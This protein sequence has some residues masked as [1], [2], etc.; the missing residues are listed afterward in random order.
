MNKCVQ[1]INGLAATASTND[2]L[3]QIKNIEKSSDADSVTMFFTLF[4][5]AYDKHRTFGVKQIPES[6]SV[7]KND[8]W[9]A[10]ISLVD[11]LEQRSLTGHAARDAIQ[12]LTDTTDADIWNVCYRPA[13]LKDM[14]C[15]CSEKLI[16]KAVKSAKFKVPVWSVQLAVDSKKHPNK[17]TGE[18][19]VQVKLDGVRLT[20]VLDVHHGTVRMFTRNGKEN[21]NFPDIKD[22]FKKILP[23]IPHSCVVDGEI[24]SDNFQ[25]LMT[26][27]NRK[28]S[29]DTSDAHYAMFDIIPLDEFNNG[30]STSNQ[31]KRHDD[32]IAF[33]IKHLPKNCDSIYVIPKTTVNLD[34]KEGEQQLYEEFDAAILCGFEGIMIKD[35]HAKYHRKRS[36]NWM[37]LKPTETIDVVVVG[38]E[39]GTGKNIG[40]LGNFVCT[41]ND[42]GKII[43]VKVGSGLS[44][45]QRQDFWNNRES[46]VGEVVE[47]MYDVIT[48]NR[49]GSYSLR[50]PRF[51]R[52]RSTGAGKF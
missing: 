29:V 1:W 14:R 6:T 37:K 3:S 25:N 43:N 18:R 30:S 38:T 7:T 44:E 2:K 27:I 11:K 10:F 5:I 21:N 4:K 48:M 47:V 22:R 41:G 42:D 34:T 31:A 15:N 36:S 12:K 49:N 39:E 50:F 9:D 13:L 16:N 46:V 24:V 20:T 52:F 45:Q 35:P 32:L 40:R 23:T 26:Q 17:M 33:A 28:V 51:K 8:N 19:F